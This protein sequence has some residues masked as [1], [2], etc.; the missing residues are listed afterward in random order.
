VGVHVCPAD[1]P[2][3]VSPL[4]RMGVFMRENRLYVGLGSSVGEEYSYDPYDFE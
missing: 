2:V 1:W 4:P 3:D